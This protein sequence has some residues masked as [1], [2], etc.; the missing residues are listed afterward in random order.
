[1]Q[2]FLLDNYT[3]LTYFVEFLAVFVG[4]LFYK[5]YKNKIAKYLVYFLAFAFLVDLIG[6]YPGVLKKL[7]M[8]YLIKD[9]WI[10]D[11]YWWYNI[12]WNL[13]LTSFIAL[14]NFKILEKAL[15]KTVLKYSFY[16][17]ISLFIAFVVFNFKAIFEPS[18]AFLTILSLWMTILSCTLYFLEILQSEKVVYFYKSIYFYINAIILLWTLVTAPLQFYEGYFDSGNKDFVVVKYTILL[19]SNILLYLT[20]TITLICFRHKTKL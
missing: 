6:Y 11:N 19:L 7:N 20:L 14:L 9:S 15:Y 4:I 10:N 5:H 1:M 8:L 2:Q 17:Y 3:T 13:G 18:M 12:F 16:V